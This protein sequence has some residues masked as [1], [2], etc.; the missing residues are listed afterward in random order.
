MDDCLVSEQLNKWSKIFRKQFYLHLNELF[1]FVS[2]QENGCIIRLPD[3]EVGPV[4]NQI[5]RREV[6]PCA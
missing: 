3:Y 1:I 6:V 4:L 2:E 5:P